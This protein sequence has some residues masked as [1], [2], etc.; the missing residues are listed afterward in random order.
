[1]LLSE[2]KP[3]TG[4]CGINGTISYASQ[5]PW[6]FPGTIRQNILCGLDY[7]VQRY[8]KVIMATGLNKDFSILTHGDQTDDAR[9]TKGQKYRINL[10]RCLYV[11][12]DI[13]LIDDPFSST[14][15]DVGRNLFREVIN[16][17]LRDKIRILTS[18]H[19]HH[20]LRDV[21]QLLVLKAV[22][23]HVLHIIIFEFNKYLN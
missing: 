3:L 8:N 13:Y 11:D 17:F 4:R 10:A 1:M 12:A 18:R 14:D 5:E 21:N 23:R 19:L 20:Y 7:N 16:G 6:I 2:L 22:I 15:P 9:L